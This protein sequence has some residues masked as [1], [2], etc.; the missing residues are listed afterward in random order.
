MFRLKALTGLTTDELKT[1]S[2][3]SNEEFAEA[4]AV[5]FA[6]YLSK[7]ADPAPQLPLGPPAAAEPM[8]SS[9][10][11]RAQAG[12]AQFIDALEIRK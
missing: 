10:S 2:T 12:V 5:G 1:I 6:A 8:S 4:Q 9:T 7:P 11:S 3:M